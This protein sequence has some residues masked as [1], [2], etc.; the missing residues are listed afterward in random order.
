MVESLTKQDIKEA[1]VEALEPLATAIQQDFLKINGRFDKVDTR[2]ENLETGQ[3][4][5]KLRLDNVAYRF[6]LQE[7]ERRIKILENKAGIKYSTSAQ[8]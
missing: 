4:E 1:V 3:E 7:L 2:L 5:I 8:S 6:E